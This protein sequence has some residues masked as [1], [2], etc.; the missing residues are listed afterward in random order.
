MQKSKYHNR[1]P[2]SAG[3]YMELRCVLATKHLCKKWSCK[4]PFAFQL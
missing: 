2:C 4:A 1:A 3:K